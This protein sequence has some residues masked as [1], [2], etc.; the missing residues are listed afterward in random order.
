M[1]TPLT[2]WLA[3][4]LWTGLL[5]A[6]PENPELQRKFTWIDAA[7]PSV[8]EIRRVADPLIQQTGSRML[9]EVNRV[10]AKKGAEAGIDDMHLKEWKLP[11]TAPGQPRITAVKR[12]S[13]RVRN[14]ASL[15]D[16]A[17]LAALLSIQTAMADGNTPPSVLVQQVEA[18]E[19]APAEWRVY[20]PMITTAACLVCHGPVDSLTPAV[21]AKLDRLYPGDKATEYHA[22]EWRGVIRVSI[23]APEKP[24][25]T[26]TP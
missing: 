25:P 5:A 4:L 26:K 22:N 21:K 9:G 8:A 7:D 12:T 3:P 24:T 14:P 16:N 18:A 17:D 6:T 20:R 11:V 2:L 19:G 15:P 23:V 13:L 1:K 10:L